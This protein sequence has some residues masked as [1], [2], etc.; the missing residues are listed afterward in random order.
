MSPKYFL[1]VF[2]KSTSDIKTPC[3]RKC[4]IIF[5]TGGNHRTPCR[6]LI[7][8]LIVPNRSSS[9]SM[10]MNA[11]TIDPP[12]VPE[13]TDGHKPSSNKQRMTPKWYMANAPPP[14]RHN[15]VL[16]K[17]LCASRTSFNVSTT[18]SSSQYSSEEM[19]SIA[20]TVSSL[21]RVASNFVPT[22]EYC[23]FI[24]LSNPA[25]FLCKIVRNAKPIAFT[26]FLSLAAIIVSAY[27]LT[28]A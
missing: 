9:E 4:A 3:W 23:N 19:N 22:R 20:R 18:S 11:A 1:V 27:P 16:P 24:N 17:L 13:T 2:P 28:N 21:N 6:T 25:K 8:S 7:S 5:H 14:E 15:P 10:E 26:S 12:D